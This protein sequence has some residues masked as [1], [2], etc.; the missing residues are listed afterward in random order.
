MK[1]VTS[2]FFLLYLGIFGLHC[3]EKILMLN[4]Y[5]HNFNKITVTE[6]ELVK[7]LSPRNGILYSY[8]KYEI[9]HGNSDDGVKIFESMYDAILDN[10]H[11][12]FITD[13]DLTRVSIPKFEWDGLSNIKG[14]NED[15]LLNDDGRVKDGIYTLRISLLRYETIDDKEEFTELTL[16]SSDD[17]QKRNSAFLREIKIKVD[18]T[19]PKISGKILLVCDD[20]ENDIYSYILTPETYCSDRDEYK[21]YTWSISLNENEL[22]TSKSESKEFLILYPS[23]CFT[24]NPGDKI[25]ISAT[26]SAENRA[27]LYLVL[28]NKFTDT[29]PQEKT[30]IT[31]LNAVST[32]LKPFCNEKDFDASGNT[33]FKYKIDKKN[34]NIIHRKHNDYPV[35]ILVKK[36]S[37]I[38]R[39]VP[40]EYNSDYILSFNLYGTDFQ[41]EMYEFLISDGTSELLL[42]YKNIWFSSKKKQINKQIGFDEREVLDVSDILF[43]PSR[44]SFLEEEDLYAQN[45]PIINSVVDIIK[46]N[47]ADIECVEIFGYA[48]PEFSTKGENILDKENREILLPLSMKRAEYVKT[49]LMLMGIPDELMKTVACGGI[50][51]EANP[52]DKENNYKN[53][54][55]R[56]NV[57]R[58]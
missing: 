27:E 37:K 3:E 12:L 21:A 52:I 7:Q 58:K 6:A 46:D 49:I 47:I 45:L 39:T 13:K 42:G 25:K 4:P 44:E 16:S 22:Y 20:F 29:S 10:N 36:N 50:P 8:V 48:N 32:T 2:V 17:E 23:V 53:R 57:V 9:F 31:Y 14:I 18:T 5:S 15:E 43:P 19:A 38:I 54:R 35:D 33:Q 24:A 56:I 51:Y 41:K 30:R 40:V 26:D 1:K 34:Q 28:P 11:E 55:V